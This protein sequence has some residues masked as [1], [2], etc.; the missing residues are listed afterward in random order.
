MPTHPVPP[1]DAA[2]SGVSRREFLKKGGSVLAAGLA[3]TSLPEAAEPAAAQTSESASAPGRAWNRP[4][5]VFLITDQERFPQHWGGLS[6]SFLPN[7]RRLADR[8]LTFENAFCNTAMCSPSRATL[9][10]GLYPAQHGVTQTLQTGD[11]AS[12]AQCTLHPGIPNMAHLLASAGYDVQ[13]RGKWHLSKDPTG[14]RDV[15]S[16]ADLARYGFNGWI[17]PDGGQDHDP[18]HFGGGDTN[19]DAQY[20]EQAAAFLRSARPRSARPFALFVSLINPHDIMAY[21]RLWN[22]PS[23]SDIPPFQGARNYAGVAPACFQYGIPLPP[24]LG[25]DLDRNFKPTAQRQSTLFWE[26]PR[27]LGPLATDQDRLNYVNF[28]YFLHAVSDAHMG[29]VLDALESNRG[30]ADNTLVIR[31]ADHG[32]MGLAHGGMRQKAYNA[33]EETLHV[34]L[35]ISNPRLFPR[36]VR[37]RA[38]ASLVDLM[39]TLA[40]IAGAPRRDSWVLPGRDLTPILLDAAA[41]PHRPTAAVQDAILFTAD[42]TLGSAYVRQP[43]HIRC[44]REAS[45]KFAMYFDPAGEAAPQFELY[46][47][48]EDPCELVNLAHPDSPHYAYAKTAEMMDKLN[49]R[50]AETGTAPG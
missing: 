6:E 17:P 31:L 12:L 48:D 46:H 8:G 24:T 34:P 38:L 50:M 10:T 39:P 18:A 11:D 25:E 29:T 45:W 30:L 4:N 27:V 15:Q 14:T 37:T 9:F 35:V 19:Y 26:D 2:S 40:T 3:M 44:L 23:A 32:E 43:A 36:P 49:R 5:L 20:A 42:E 22:A 33:Y 28:Y 13:Y 47:L 16:P 7:R 21:P 1:S 41:R